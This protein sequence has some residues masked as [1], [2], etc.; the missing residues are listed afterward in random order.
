MGI[1]SGLRQL[2]YYREFRIPASGYSGRVKEILEELE[3]ALIRLA[4]DKSAKQPEG[5]DPRLLAEIGTGLWRLKQKMVRPG[6]DRP[7]EEMAKAFRHLESVW[8]VLSQAGVEIQDHTGKPF[9]SGLA[10][11]VLAFQPVPG[12]DREKIIETI[13]PTIYLNGE[14]IQQGTVI[15]GTKGDHEA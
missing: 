5:G 3:N 13:N 2:L 8:D 6:T 1:L 9:D 4:E 12:I 11:R 14:T 7:L 10:L 15:V